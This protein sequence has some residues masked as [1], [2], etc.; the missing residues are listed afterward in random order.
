MEGHGFWDTLSKFKL[1]LHSGLLCLEKVSQLLRASA[2]RRRH[3]PERAPGI[4]SVLTK[5]EPSL[6]SSIVVSDSCTYTHNVC[7]LDTW[8]I[9]SRAVPLIHGTA[10]IPLLLL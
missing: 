1:E 3:E 10:G 4:W 2:G 8:I 7:S 9:P 5:Q 6:L